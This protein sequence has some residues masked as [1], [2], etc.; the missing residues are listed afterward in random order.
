MKA[1]S[2]FL[3]WLPSLTPFNDKPHL[4]RQ[5]MAPGECPLRLQTE[6]HWNGRGW[7]R[8]TSW[9]DRKTIPPRSR[10]SGHSPLALSEITSQPNQAFS[11]CQTKPSSKEPPAFPAASGAPSSGRLWNCTSLFPEP[12]DRIPFVPIQVKIWG[13]LLPRGDVTCKLTVQSGHPVP[14]QQYYTAVN[15]R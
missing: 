4:R 5:T 11:T 9:G 14:L 3:T 7:C 10:S 6:P 8:R 15:S 13:H 1:P 12:P 2:S